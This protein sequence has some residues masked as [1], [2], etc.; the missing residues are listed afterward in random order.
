MELSATRIDFNRSNS[1]R[2]VVTTAY[3][4]KRAV[5]NR[6]KS[7]MMREVLLQTEH[8]DVIIQEGLLL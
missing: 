1:G 3:L 8:A 5:M 4:K 7:F 6:G 2:M